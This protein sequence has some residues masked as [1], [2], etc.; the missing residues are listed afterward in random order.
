[1]LFIWGRKGHSETLGFTSDRVRCPNCSNI[2]NWSIVGFGK[3]ATIYFVP[4]FKYGME[5]AV[6]CPVCT[7]G[8]GLGKGSIGKQRAHELAGGGDIERVLATA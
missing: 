5:Y 3:R 6:M 4:T 8:V 7:A 1:M 2:R